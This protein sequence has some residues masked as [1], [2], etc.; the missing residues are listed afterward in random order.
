MSDIYQSESKD[1]SQLILDAVP[2]GYRF[3]RS[4]PDGVAGSYPVHDAFELPS[5]LP[6]GCVPSD[7]ARNEGAGRVAMKWR[8]GP[9]NGMLP[10]LEE[11]QPPTEN[12]T[13]PDRER[14]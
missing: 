9:R 1:A 8:V 11:S 13:L 6:H 3:E 2:I 14:S 12:R 10:I 7:T 5:A 4:L